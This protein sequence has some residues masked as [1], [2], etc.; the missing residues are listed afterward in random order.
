[1]TSCTRVLTVHADARESSTAVQARAVVLT[2]RRQ[3]FVDVHLTARSRK[4]FSTVAPAHA[5]AD[6]KI[7][8]K[9]TRN[10]TGQNQVTIRKN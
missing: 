4:A 8:V 6:T 3:T 2:R 10:A 5:Y 1:M 9:W 7:I